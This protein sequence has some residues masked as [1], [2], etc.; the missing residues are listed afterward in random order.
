MSLHKL[1]FLTLNCWGL[2]DLITGAVYQKYGS[3]LKRH[4]R[5]EMI[6]RR[7]CE[8][9]YDVVALQE[10]WVPSDKSLVERVCVGS[11]PYLAHFVAGF[12]FV[13]GGLT[14]LSKFPIEKT[15]FCRFS[16]NGKVWICVL[17]LLALGFYT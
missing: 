7:L 13:G 6:A 5:I 16:L 15:L 17:F 3:S 2:P 11:F 12:P 4:Q 14:I 9:H 8:S 1:S 10:L